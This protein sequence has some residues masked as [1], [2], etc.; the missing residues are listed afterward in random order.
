MN[1][2]TALERQYR[3]AI[4]AYP[5]RWRA[6][7]GDE[8]LDVMLD[9]AASGG[10]TKPRFS[11]VADLAWHGVGTRVN[12]VLSLMPRHRRNHTAAVGVI[13]GTTLA[14]VMMVLGELGRWFRWN[15]YGLTD[16]PFGLFTTFAAPALGCTLLAFLAL[17]GGRQTSAKVLHAAAAGASLIGFLAVTLLEPLVPVH[18]MVFCFFGVANLLALL[19]NPIRTL[20]LRRLVLVGSPLLGVLLTITCYLQGGGA[21]RTFWGGP[22]I[23]NDFRLAFWF[24]ELLIVAVLLAVVG[25]KIR[26]WACLILVPLTAFPLSGMFISLG[27]DS[28]VGR[29]GISPE[30]FYIFCSLAGLVSAWASWRRPTISWAGTRQL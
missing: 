19:G 27:G 22:Y 30:V 11:E 2:M 29:I 25:T 16:Q 23:I 13:S 24:S 6:A 14:L 10:R 7:H 3:R 26:P 18:P 8:L 20:G 4:R 5:A 1:E 15:S 21:Q 9:V 17:A 28:T 12:Q